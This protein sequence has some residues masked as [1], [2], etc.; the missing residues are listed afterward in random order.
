[1]G[2]KNFKKGS[3]RN[4]TQDYERR[5]AWQAY[6]QEN[7]SFEAYYKVRYSYKY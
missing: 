6:Q 1:M 7:E 4:E 2:K 5:P 3:R